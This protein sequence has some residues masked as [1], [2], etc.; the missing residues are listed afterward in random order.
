MWQEKI[1]GELSDD[2]VKLLD[3][4]RLVAKKINNRVYWVRQFANKPDHPYLTHRAMKNCHIVE[5]VFSFYDLCVAKMT[6]F[7]KHLHLYNPC[8]ISYRSGVLVS[9]EVWDMEF[10]MQRKTGIVIDLRNLAAISDITVFREMCSWLEQQLELCQ[11]SYDSRSQGTGLVFKRPKK[12]HSRRHINYVHQPDNG[13][14]QCTY[15]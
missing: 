14:I 3:K 10:L 9:C 4:Y 2:K 11:P 12:V 1:K 8:K 7:K 6:Y 5:L 15:F 13:G